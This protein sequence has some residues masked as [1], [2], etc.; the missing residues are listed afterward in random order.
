MNGR[1]EVV[2]RPQQELIREVCK[3]VNKREDPELTRWFREQL[4]ASYPEVNWYI[5]QDTG[6]LMGECRR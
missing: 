3:I 6:R 5:H 2:M 1:M 4:T